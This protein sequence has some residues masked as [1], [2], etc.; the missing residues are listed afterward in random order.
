MIDTLIAS[1]AN[2]TVTAT[3][4]HGSASLQWFTPESEQSITLDILLAHLSS[5]AIVRYALQSIKVAVFNKARP[6]LLASGSASKTTAMKAIVASM[7]PEQIAKLV[8]AGVITQ[9]QADSIR[10]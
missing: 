7:K 9:E 2:E 4:K 6:K 8:T 5:D 1:V 10:V 3:G